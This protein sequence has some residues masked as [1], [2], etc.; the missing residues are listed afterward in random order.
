MNRLY[1]TLFDQKQFFIIEDLTDLD[2][3]AVWA[4]LKNQASFFPTGVREMLTYASN[5]DPARGLEVW[6]FQSE[7]RRPDLWVIAKEQAAEFIDLI[8]QEG[9]LVFVQKVKEPV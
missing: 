3:K 9:T 1:I 6:T 2:K 7:L 8:K 4:A 5:S